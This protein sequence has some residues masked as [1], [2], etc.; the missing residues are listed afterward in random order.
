MS[1]VEVKKLAESW[2]AE[3]KSLHASADVDGTIVIEDGKA[4]GQRPNAVRIAVRRAYARDIETRAKAML[5][6]LCAQPD[7]EPICA[8]EPTKQPNVADDSARAAIEQL[9]TAI[10]VFQDND[11]VHLSYHDGKALVTLRDW[12]RERLGRRA[13]S[14][15]RITELESEVAALREERNAIR[16]GFKLMNLDFDAMAKLCIKEM[17]AKP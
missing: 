8:H 6:A 1:I 13:N 7:I 2:L 12:A 11:R 16:D 3:A 4:V 10:R 15:T 5:D 14:D 17:K 9:E